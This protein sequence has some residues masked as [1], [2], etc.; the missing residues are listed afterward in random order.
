MLIS[1]P[2]AMP[3]KST[4][5]KAWIGTEGEP[6]HEDRREEKPEEQ[7]VDGAGAGGGGVAEAPRHPLDGAQSVPDDRDVFGAGRRRR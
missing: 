2:I 1:M 7:S 4:P 3:T 6:E 5:T